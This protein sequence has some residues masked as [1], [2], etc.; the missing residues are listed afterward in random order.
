MSPHITKTRG[1]FL[2]STDPE[3]LDI[4]A[5]HAYI[6]QRSYWGRNVPFS[7]VQLALQNSLV[8]GLYDTSGRIYKQI[9]C[10]RWITD[11]ATFGY[12]SDV[13]VEEEYQG[14]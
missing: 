1:E 14:K 5:V 7:T 12:L 11:Y 6:S 13:Y 3:L 4:P 9:G 8:V 10:G 2:A